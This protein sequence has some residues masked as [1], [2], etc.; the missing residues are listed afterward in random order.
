M[1]E[2]RSA[3]SQR[4]GQILALDPGAPALEFEGRWFT[5]GE[6]A[7]D[8][9]AVARRSSPESGWRCCCATARRTS[10]CWSGCSRPAPASSRS[11]PAAA[12]DR[13]RSDL[14][15]LGVGTGRRPG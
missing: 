15:D 5:W 11:I 2:P 4:I 9:H 12:I 10:A 14:A 7:D 6:I 3:L 13:V 8:R 1:A